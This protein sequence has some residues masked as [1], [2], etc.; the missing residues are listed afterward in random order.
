MLLIIDDNTTFSRF[1]NLLGRDFMSKTLYL[2]QKRKRG[3]ITSSTLSRYRQ[4]PMFHKLVKVHAEQ[5]E[6]ST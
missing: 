4:T 2:A 3:Q 6:P 1:S 5:R